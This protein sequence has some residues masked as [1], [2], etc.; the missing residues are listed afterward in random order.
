MVWI[1]MQQSN[2]V[3]WKGGKNVLPTL[4]EVHLDT[5]LHILKVD[6]T[7]HEHLRGYCQITN[8][9]QI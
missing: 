3:L 4:T 2:L 6:I 8:H 9:N 5:C 7:Y 1:Q